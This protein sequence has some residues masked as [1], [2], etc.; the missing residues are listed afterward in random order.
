MRRCILILMLLISLSTALTA[1]EWSVSKSA[2]FLV[3]Y[4]NAPENFIK[5]LIDEA[6]GYYNSIVSEL[7][8]S[9]Y[10]FWL[11]DNRTTV[12][13]YDDAEN[14]RSATGQPGWSGGA[15]VAK[16]KIIYTYP[17]DK[18]FFGSIL[19][20][21]LGH[22]IFREFVGF[23][24]TAIPLWLEEG[25]ASYQEKLKYS[26]ADSLVRDAFNN[27]SFIPLGEISV[28]NLSAAD[29]HTATLFYCESFSLVKFL[30]QKF[31][32]DNFTHF[33]RKLRDKKELESAL[34]LAYPF[35]NPEELQEAWKQYL[36]R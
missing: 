33:C 22:I 2:H 10:E 19:P 7:G 9:R 5:K 29:S 13:V 3:R 6:E 27:G 23:D 14:Y 20:H 31:G 25:V 18:D 4:N 30:L 8:F 17:S 28:F 32:K 11:W 24:N 21:E 12:Y 26:A 34:N 1:G 15:A 16:E 36:S 35:S